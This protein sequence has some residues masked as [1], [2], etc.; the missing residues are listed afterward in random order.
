MAFDPSTDD[1][2]VIDRCMAGDQGAMVELLE[3]FRGQVYGLCYRM[4]NN[5]QDAEDALQE[6]F[7]RVFRN[8]HSWDRQRD[9]KPWLL[10]IAGNRCRTLLG[11]RK[12]R[13]APTALVDELLDS[14]DSGD[15][16]I[17]LVEE[18]R[19][20]LLGLREEYR[21]A[22]LLFHEQ[23]L[24]YLEIAEILDCPVGTVKTWIHR[25]RRE[26]AHCL[27]GRGVVEDAP[28]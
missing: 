2:C 11:A 17:T 22:F 16:L 20:A 9:F 19:L 23:E 26:L 7:I 3:R 21:R 6:T 27:R 10:A 24:S 4:L 12:R 8:L 18:V 13:P 15:G 25:A 1:R 28:L 14:S 5:R